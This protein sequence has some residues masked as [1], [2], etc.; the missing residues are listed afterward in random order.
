MESL[1]PITTVGSRPA[2]C[3]RW[4]TMAVTVVFPW[5]PATATEDFRRMSSASIS[6]RGMTGIP[7]LFAASTSGFWGDTALE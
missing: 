5:E 3:A 1:P 4:A 6:A 2:L 7:A